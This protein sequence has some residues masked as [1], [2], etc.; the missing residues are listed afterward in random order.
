MNHR[1]VPADPDR[2]QPGHLEVRVDQLTW[3]V[4]DLTAWRAI[5][6]AWLRAHQLLDR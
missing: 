6:D 4:C 1:F 2:R 3:Q 5:G